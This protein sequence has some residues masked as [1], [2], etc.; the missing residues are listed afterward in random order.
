MRA[1]RGTALVELVTTLVVLGILL[2]A[3][4]ALIH[5]Q[6]GLVKTVSEGAA[7]AEALRTAR[8]VLR[9][10]LRDLDTTD[11]RAISADSLA[12]RVYRA[13]GIVCAIDH[14]IISLRYRGVRN[15]DPAKDSLLL[16]SD[17][18]VIAFGA[19]AAPAESCVP[20]ADEQLV[21]IATDAKVRLN[22]VVLLF[23]SG[24]YHLA[25]HALRYRLGG[26]GRQ[27]ITDE[28][29]DDRESWFGAEPGLRG[30]AV[31]LR[32]RAL[33]EAARVADTRIGFSNP[34]P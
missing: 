11:V 1:R 26:G 8:L 18:R 5:S 22:E 13:W 7:A 6:T 17:A 20:R 25:N 33:H 15:P 29:L 3:C 16:V 34:L 2:A 32:S 31:R 10:E 19:A 9:A 21:F 12:T 4:A 14:R 24:A 28:L 27:P 23:E 30:V